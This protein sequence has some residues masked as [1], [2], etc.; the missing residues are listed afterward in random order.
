MSVDHHID[1]EAK[2]IITSLNGD[3]IDSELVEILTNYFRDIKSQSRYEAYNE[4]IDL[5]NVHGFKLEP[6]KIRELATI[7][8]SYDKDGIN[9]KLAIIASSILAFGLAKIYEIARKIDRKSCKEVRVF[10][11][12][13]DAHEW[14]GLPP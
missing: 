11:R 8:S 13:S 9:T 3:A 6:Q 2:V 4:I 10:K 14:L 1:D 7:S 5:R 12:L